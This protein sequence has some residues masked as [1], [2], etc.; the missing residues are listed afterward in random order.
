MKIRCAQK[1]ADPELPPKYQLLN[2]FYF[3]NIYFFYLRCKDGE[4]DCC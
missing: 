3:Q 4:Y 2:E 1:C